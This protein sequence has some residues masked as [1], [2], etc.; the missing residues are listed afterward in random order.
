MENDRAYR[1]LRTKLTRL[2][3]GLVAMEAAV[4]LLRLAG[5][6]AALLALNVLIG[7]A[8]LPPPARHA[9]ATGSLGLLLLAASVGAGALVRGR[10]RLDRI[11]AEAEHSAP[12]LRGD[13]I[14]G[15]LDLGG[16]GDL[17]A[18]GYS[19][20]LVGALIDRALRD[21]AAIRRRRV[22][23]WERLRRALPIL[24][25]AAAAT[26]A[27]LFLLPDRTGVVF[28]SIGPFDAKKILAEMGLRVAPGDCDVRE[29]EEVAVE[30]R[31]DRYDGGDA[32]LFVRPDGG[33]SWSV[34]PMGE[35]AA[36]T[37][38][39]FE[40]RIPAVERDAFYRIRF[41][42]GESP[43]FR[44]TLVRPPVLAGIAYRLRRPAYAG[45]A[46]ERI[47]EN[48]GNVRALVGTE[49]I[50]EGRVRG[51]VREARM[52]IEGGEALP[53][54]V[55]GDSLA[56]SFTVEEPFAYTIVLVDGRGNRNED[57][58]RYE[59]VPVED[60]KPF[61]R[62]VR[63][64]E[65]IELDRE[66]K[67]PLDFAA[68]DDFGVSRVDLVWWKNE[69]E[70]SRESLFATEHRI[71]RVE[72][73]REWDLS[74][75]P[76]LP[77]ETIRYR[78]EAWDNDAVSGPKRGVSRTFTLRMPSL[79]EI[80]AEV[81]GGQEEEIEDLEEIYTESRSLE[82]KLDEL[83]RE[84]K[85]SE[86]VSWDEK[87]KIEN[88]LR[89]QKEIEEALREAAAEIDRAT[90]RLETDR[91]ITPETVERMMELSRLLEEVATDEMREAL[92]EMQKAMESLDREELDRAMENLELSQEDF[93]EQ[94]D[95][96]I[97]ALKRFKDLQDMDAL[98]E[99]LR[100][101]AEKQ[102]ELRERTESAEGEELERLAE[103]QEALKEDFEKMSGEM[104]ELAERSAERGDQLSEEMKE[105]SRETKERRIGEKMDRASDEMR[106]QD[107]T[108]ATSAQKQ[109]EKDLFDLS[110]RLR[111]TVD[112]IC[113]CSK[114]KSSAAFGESVQDL[115]YLSKRQEEILGGDEWSRR[116]PMDAR[117]SLAERQQD[118]VS[119]IGRVMEKVR[120]VGRDVPLLSSQVL[121]L[122]RRAR[123]HA[124]GAIGE[125]EQGNLSLAN[126]SGREAMLHMNR[127]VVELLRSMESHSASC[128]NPSG[129]GGMPRMQQMTERQ[130]QLNDASQQL[131]T[132]S[133]NPTS[134]S[135]QERA[136]LSRMAAEQ[137]AVRKGMEDLMQEVE[138]GGDLAGRLDEI[139][140][141]MRKVE[142]EL[143]NADLSPETRE[144]QERILSRMLDAQRSLRERGYRKLRRSE[145]AGEAAAR[146]TP[147]P[148]G[149]VGRE[150]EEMRDDPFREDGF[151]SPP[152][153]E[154]LIRAY[155]RALEERR[156]A[157]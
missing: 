10:P 91:L 52:E 37:G 29:G 18:H 73:G 31:F 81:T 123:R 60:E 16:R 90:E 58:I 127:S 120:D 23:G 95:R 4:L 22:V 109:A 148:R 111:E 88:A 102:R 118:V 116:S 134:L 25:F 28:R 85:E 33:E 147:G 68:L 103:E 82:E 78:L 79:A 8:P 43:L 137:Q 66:M 98:A 115:L 64:G 143:E 74:G 39:L 93:L 34:Y 132:P 89:K 56:G 110:F 13:L 121:D 50:L 14:R 153:Y 69:G 15:A 106:D 107:G 11:A 113:S 7:F 26:A 20:P 21:S 99:G 108:E 54:R 146:E 117:R 131:P 45:L 83:A 128:Q 49:V 38:R 156:G 77:Q 96:A 5:V 105:A 125:I 53:L 55:A 144:R 76:L 119:G 155:F 36:A 142:Q 133:A 17:A 24:P 70:E 12:E 129:Q 101:M 61:V 149:P 19:L 124:E 2:R 72:R 97:D 145:T 136:Q 41:D 135:M 130:R 104:E 9:L 67:V 30:A 94:L 3:R 151:V 92:R 84:I 27:L 75:E 47:D 100:Q 63:P 150:L 32:R 152:E 62:V 141:E 157:P 140:E 59:V 57:P 1:M 51:P 112:S 46:E 139:T 154:E 40:G 126:N 80:F 44:I 65:D 6:A 71:A 42:G 87:Q 138:E 48:H 114:Q 86:N 122:L 35:R